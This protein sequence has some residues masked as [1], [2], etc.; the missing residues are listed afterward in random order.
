MTSTALG[1]TMWLCEDEKKEK[2]TLVIV[3]FLRMLDSSV[4]SRSFQLAV[5][6]WWKR[7]ASSK[8]NV[9]LPSE[10]A[11][12]EQGYGFLFCLM[13]STSLGLTI[14]FHVRFEKENHT[15]VGEIWFLIM[16]DGLVGS[17]GF[18]LAV[19]VYWKWEAFSKNNA[20]YV[21]GSVPIFF[22]VGAAGSGY[23]T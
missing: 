19:L 5:N 2:H 13:T 11:V 18:Q 15:L 23:F 9:I 20:N 7:E 21:S 17:R 8:N 14:H 4:S 3:W 16:P 6:A 12:A 1:L 10:R 22:R